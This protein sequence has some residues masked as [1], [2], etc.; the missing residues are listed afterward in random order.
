MVNK[1][2]GAANVS[3]E[4]FWREKLKQWL[5]SG[6]SQA[7]FCKIHEL[8]ENSLSYWKVEIKKRDAMVGSTASTPEKKLKRSEEKLGVWGSMERKV[9][10][11]CLAAAG[12]LIATEKFV[13][14]KFSK[15]MLSRSTFEGAIEMMR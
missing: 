11:S 4:S 3:R 1:K 6:Q 10:L 13:L 9:A 8:S 15:L 5:E 2:S 12:K 14:Q 7:A